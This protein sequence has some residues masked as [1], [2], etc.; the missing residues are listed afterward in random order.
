M[1]KE[2]S[3]KSKVITILEDNF[4]FP[5]ELDDWT[6][7]SMQERF[8]K[9]AIEIEKVV[10]ETSVDKEWIYE[11]MDKTNAFAKQL[12]ENHFNRH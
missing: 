2:E 9:V 1:T 3:F 4:G 12:I 6:T 5:E 11:I 7:I 10:K 8:I